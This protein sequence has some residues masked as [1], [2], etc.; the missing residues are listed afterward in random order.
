MS[1]PVRGWRRSG[2]LWWPLGLGALL[3]D[4]ASKELIR[5]QLQLHESIYLLPV[6]NIVHARNYGAAWS[7][8][9]VP[10]G[11]QRWLFTLFALA[12][13]GGLLL[14][15]RRAGGLVHRPQN[16]GLMLIVSGAL[17]NAVDRLRHGYVVDFIQVHWHSAYFPA[18]N[19]ADSCITVGAGLILLEALLEWRRERHST[20]GHGG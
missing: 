3:L 6:F 2:L 9:D 8:L 16:A 14:A 13:A 1:E 19:V 5:H 15:L 18:F 10:G 7:F 4:Q 17:G 11:W 12:V 20:G